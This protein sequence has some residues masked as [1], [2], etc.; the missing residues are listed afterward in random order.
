MN[1]LLVARSIGRRSASEPLDDEGHAGIAFEDAERSWVAQA[2]PVQGVLTGALT[3]CDSWPAAFAEARGALWS[4]PDVTELLPV[5]ALAERD[6]PVALDEVAAFV[7]AF[8]ARGLAYCYDPGPNSNSFVRLL[9]QAIGWDLPHPPAG[10]LLRGW[11]W[12]GT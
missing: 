8:N 10:A 5:W 11:G 4:S 1:V 6:L 7:T 12:N 3:A 2:G 9:L